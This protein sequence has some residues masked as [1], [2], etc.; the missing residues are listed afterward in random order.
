MADLSGIYERSGLADD[1]IRESNHRI[2][3]QL[4]LLV[5]MIHSQKAAL[6]RGPA[7]VS[8]EAAIG[9]LTEMAARIVALSHL[10]RR[11]VNVADREDVDL[12]DLLIESCVE[13]SKT[14]ALG[15]RVRFRHA[16]D[17]KCPVSAEQASVL[18]LIVSEIVMNAVKYAHPTGLPVEVTVACSVTR[19]GR[20]CL[21]ISDDG[22]GLPEGF[23][24]NE[25]GGV[26]FK[27]IRSLT[28]KVGADLTIRSDDLGLS[29][30]IML[31]PSARAACG[32]AYDALSTPPQ[33]NA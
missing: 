7:L 4:S 8:R 14:L 26:G 33:G 11:L 16:L 28:A 18:S 23:D 30:S 29:F 31:P 10:H 13:L 12:P 27:I 2:A 22:V 17:A 15:E 20:T 6:K 24:E 32:F 1:L 25:N 9:M 21:E 5:A 3:N 19:E